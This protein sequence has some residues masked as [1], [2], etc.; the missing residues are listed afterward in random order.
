MRDL[1][2][3]GEQT[4]ILAGPEGLA[5]VIQERGEGASASWGD[6][7]RK[8]PEPGCTGLTLSALGSNQLCPLR[9]APWSFAGCFQWLAYLVSKSNLGY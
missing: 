1:L 2:S 9:R 4:D 3:L 5:G 8:G 7:L 6:I